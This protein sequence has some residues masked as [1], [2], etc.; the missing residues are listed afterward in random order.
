MS[1]SGLLAAGLVAG[2]VSGWALTSL[3]PPS[4]LVRRAAETRACP[5][6]EAMAAARS[7]LEGAR[8][9]RA[10]VVYRRPY[11]A[12]VRA[13]VVVAR[14]PLVPEAWLSGAKTVVIPVDVLFAVD[15][16]AMSPGDL[17]LEGDGRLLRVARP[18]VRPVAAEPRFAEAAVEVQGALLVWLADAEEALDRAA[19]GRAVEAAMGAAARED[20]LAMP[21]L[22]ADRAI[23]RLF[24]VG[25]GAAGV[26]GV[27]VE[28]AART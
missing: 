3:V 22:E 23:A 6:P 19:Y 15:L 12:R 25:L 26:R 16:S 4:G 5:C 18:P 27:R 1:R 21:G 8:R 13:P 28:V 11:L 14:V 7:V 9:E 20:D 2:L 17:A 10:L 24:E